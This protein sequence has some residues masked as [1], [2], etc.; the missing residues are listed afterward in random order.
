ME[1]CKWWAEH[2]LI[3]N[4]WSF[5]NSCGIWSIIGYRETY[6]QRGPQTLLFEH[7]VL[8]WMEMIRNTKAGGKSERQQHSNCCLQSMWSPETLFSE[9]WQTHRTPIWSTDTIKEGWTGIAASQNPYLPQQYHLTSEM[10]P[11]TAHFLLTPLVPLPSWQHRAMANWNRLTVC[12]VIRC[13][14]LTSLS[15][16]CIQAMVSL[17]YLNLPH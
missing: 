4:L 11:L 12:K 15:S 3:W 9:H 5:G 10:S 17:S 6:V 7:Y 14:I 8:H 2:D 13:T 1:L 16:E